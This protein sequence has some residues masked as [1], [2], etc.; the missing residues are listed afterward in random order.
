MR[1]SFDQAAARFSH[2]DGVISAL[3]LDHP[4]GLMEFGIRFYP[5]WEHPR[6][7]D[8]ARR[9]ARWG[10]SDTA[11]AERACT[12]HASGVEVLHIEAGSAAT[13]LG[14]H[15]EH[16]LLWQH[17]QDRRALIV[18]SEVDL[19]ALLPALDVRLRAAGLGC[20]PT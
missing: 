18:N 13:V 6:Y 4:A 19:A 17:D 7:A 3:H 9:G 12:L 20:S 10:F 16:P 11:E 5:W 15:R 1:L 14:F 8:A 2:V